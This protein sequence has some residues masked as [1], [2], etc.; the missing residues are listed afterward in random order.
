MMEFIVVGIGGFIGS[1]LR[2]AINKTSIHITPAFPLGTLLSNVI[3]GFFIG[4]IFGID[5]NFG[6]IRPKMKLFLTTGLMGGL[7]TF[8]TFSVETINLKI[9]QC[10]VLL[11][12]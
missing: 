3:A 8:S 2:F 7:S 12:S 10:T 9:P 5:Q 1:C 6:I 11:F 4:I